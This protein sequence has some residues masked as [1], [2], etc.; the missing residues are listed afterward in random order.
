MLNEKM[1]AHAQTLGTILVLYSWFCMSYGNSTGINPW[2]IVGYPWNLAA[3][4]MG[5]GLWAVVGIYWRNKNMIIMNG[6]ISVMAF[7]ALF[8]N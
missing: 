4:A 5:C 6:V 1:L 8:T 2:Y 3:E 7:I